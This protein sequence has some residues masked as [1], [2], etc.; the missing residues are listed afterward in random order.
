MAESDAPGAARLSREVVL[1]AGLDRIALST[2][3][4]KRRAPAGPKGD[5]YG[6]ASKESVNLAFPFNVPD[7]QVRL[8]LPLGGVIRP[9]VDQIDRLVQELVRRRQLG[10]RVGG[11][12]GRH[13]GHARHAARATRRA[14]GQP[15]QLADRPEDVADDG[16]A[17]PEALSVVDEQP[18]GDELPSVPGGPGDVPVRARTAGGLDPAAAT[19]LVTGLSQ[20]LL[21]IP[22]SPTA[23]SGR[24]RLQLSNDRVVGDAL[25]PSD[26]G[27][28]WILRLYNVSDSEQQVGVEWSEP[29]PRSLFLSGTSEARGSELSGALTIPAWGMVTIRAER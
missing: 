21:A 29:K 15:A 6:P 26:D 25:K 14:H 23:P 3:M 1:A 20:P 17:D 19:R 12:P 8:E 18:L 16:R 13:V 24:A 27:K 10:G 9:D 28:G 4:D 22:A 2:T 7:G 11:R 5:Y